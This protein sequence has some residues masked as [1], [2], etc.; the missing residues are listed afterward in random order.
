MLNLYIS[1]DE[2]DKQTLRVPDFVEE[3]KRYSDFDRIILCETDKSEDSLCRCLNFSNNLIDVCV[4]FCSKESRNI[5]KMCEEVNLAFNSGLEIIPI[6]HNSS[7]VFPIIRH[8]RGVKIIKN[9]IEPC[10]VVKHVI[11]IIRDGKKVD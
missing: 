11:E 1:Y 8:K 6:Y 2:N 9:N 7:D 10:D 3:I 5:V 4:F